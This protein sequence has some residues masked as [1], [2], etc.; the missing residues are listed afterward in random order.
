MTS[1]QLYKQTHEARIIFIIKFGTG[2]FNSIGYDRWKANED[3][4]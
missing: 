1:T 3:F 2:H 4:L